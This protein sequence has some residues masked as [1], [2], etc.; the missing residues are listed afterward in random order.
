MA[1]LAGYRRGEQR[2]VPGF[3]MFTAVSGSHA[4]IA[5][6]LSS[7]NVSSGATGRNREHEV[8]K[9]SRHDDIDDRQSG[10]KLSM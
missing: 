2:R 8:D 5:N 10:T 9:H 3:D 6:A 4:I 7:L 1:T